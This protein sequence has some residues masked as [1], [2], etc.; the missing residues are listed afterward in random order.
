M[1]KQS[2]NG[3]LIS[4]S[5]RRAGMTFYIRQGEMVSR[6]S[7]SNEKRSCTR[8]QFVQRQRMRH[9]I[10]LWHT[11][12]MAGTP[13]FTERKTAYRGFAALANRLPAVYAPKA[14]SDMSVLMPELP[15]SEGTLPAVK[16]ELGIINGTPAL[17]TNLKSS[18]MERREEL[19]LYTA[20]QFVDELMPRVRFSV[21]TVPMS[22]FVKHQGCLA[23]TGEEFA[24]EMKGWALVRVVP[25][26][27]DEGGRMFSGR[28]STQSLVT[29]CTHYQQYTT[30]EA[31]SAA[32]KTYGGLT[33]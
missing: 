16:L 2:P 3:M 22:E 11:L 8:A 20:M 13:L 10:A 23:L 29:R 4:G 25:S 12:E 27:T 15:V 19:R 9:T 24:D 1:K 28:C 6:V 33:E 7:H 14:Q 17:L 26:T 31:L 5:F 30:D 21:R 32:A 18:D